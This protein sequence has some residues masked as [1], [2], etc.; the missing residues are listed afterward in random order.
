MFGVYTTDPLGAAV[1]PQVGGAA[2]CVRAVYQCTYGVG[3]Y[4]SVWGVRGK[5][6]TTQSFKRI[7]SQRRRDVQT[8]IHRRND[9]QRHATKTL[10]ESLIETERHA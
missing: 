8:L 6:Q 5:D 4:L 1:E 7:F 2:K 10:I 3:G 9:T